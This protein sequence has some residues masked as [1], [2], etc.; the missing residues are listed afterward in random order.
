[1]EWNTLKYIWFLPY[2]NLMTAFADRFYLILFYKTPPPPCMWAWKS[3]GSRPPT[4][5]CLVKKNGKL[6][7]FFIYNRSQGKV[8]L[9]TLF[10]RIIV[11]ST[12]LNIFQETVQIIIFF[13]SIKINERQNFELL[14]ELFQNIINMSSLLAYLLN[15][16]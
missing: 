11:K 14:G 13:K 1:M 3:L 9:Y 6:D 8:S 2:S 16:F 4:D 10:S 7:F 5:N 12:H 15:T